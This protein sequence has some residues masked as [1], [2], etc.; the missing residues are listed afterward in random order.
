MQEE[1]LG[2]T[3]DMDRFRTNIRDPI[4]DRLLGPGKEFE[5][6]TIDVAGHPRKVFKGAPRNLAGLY[7]LAEPFADRVL[8]VQ[9]G[10]RITF[11]EGFARAASLAKHL[12]E[13]FGVKEGTVVAVVTSNRWEWVIALLA[14]TAAGG[15]AALVNSRGVA[16]EMLRAMD[17]VS[18]E[19]AII[20]AERADIIAAERP[21]PEWPR[22]L[23]GTPQAPLREGRDADFAA[24]S[25][26]RPSVEFEPLELDS[27]A[28]AV[29]LFTSGTTGF[30]KG[31]LISH[32]AIAHSATLSRF[33]G[34]LQDRRYE[35][36][37]G[38]TLPDDR[39]SMATPLVILG[40]MFHLGG[41]VPAFRA[42]SVGTT[43]HIMS[44]WNADIAFEMIETIGMS[45]LSFVPAMLWDMFRSP[46]ATPETL[47]AICYMMNGAAPLNPE[48]VAEIRKRMPNCLIATTYGQTEDTAW[49][50]SN[51]GRTYI[52]NP[53]TVGWA[54]PT[55]DVAIRRDDGSEAD[56][57][58]PGEVWVA[59]ACLMNEYYNNPEATRE[60]LRDGW[61]ASG[62]IGVFDE[63]GLLRIVDRKKNM[64]I[65][66]GE[67][68]Y[69]AEVERV[70]GD[71]PGVREAIAYGKPDE[72][73]GERLAATVVTES[74]A[75]MTDQEVKDHCK[76]HLAIYKVPR[77]VDFR[78]DALPRTATG[79]VDRGRFLKSVR[80]GA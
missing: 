33:M 77:E 51:S 79:K 7:R 78:T 55:I 10:T 3:I 6:E 58:E 25:A 37:T 38:E 44:K 20:D 12:R 1:A 13:D 48:L 60:A 65:S 26:P 40:P 16:E 15:V 74:G 62:D 59:S 61:L 5:L 2:P 22:I 50:T 73:L 23:I 57:G 75:A 21:D 47:G 72:R 24:L 49:T 32:G 54:C 52:E 39:R 63:K 36:E 9:D 67:N 27:S 19:L 18:C 4:V 71:I 42:V 34:A 43:I 64:V 70:L 66:G 31:A 45:R 30:P 76:Q 28:G 8:V 11:A 56:V 46:R 14:I 29:I 80:E 68:I 35:E 17:T 53:D 41:L 69:C